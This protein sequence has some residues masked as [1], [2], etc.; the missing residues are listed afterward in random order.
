[1]QICR[2]Y[3]PEKGPRLGFVHEGEVYDLTGVAPERFGSLSSLLANPRLAD[4][5][6]ENQ[7]N[8]LGQEHFAFE[9]LDGP[10]APERPHLLAPI[11]R[12]EV[13]AAGVTYLRS[14]A[15]RVEESEAA[16]NHYERVY[17]APR[18]ELFFKGT[19]H[20]TVGPNSPVRIRTDSNWNVPEPELAL[21]ISPDLR[22]A[23]FT[24]GNDMSSRDIE[25]ENPLYLPQAKIYLE[26]CAL[27]PVVTLSEAVSNPQALSITMAVERGEEVIFSGQTSTSQ[28]K[29]GFQELINYL[30]RANAFPD[31]VFL[32]TG[33]GIVPPSDFTLEDGDLVIM[34]IEAIGTLRNPVKRA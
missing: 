8:I 19:P 29:R 4:E 16:A 17:D 20:R 13:W 21:L 11:D 27:G 33:T 15:A 7:P 6:D 12:Q 14:R 30:G 1:M 10:P 23:G 31:G 2:F 5:L 26:S 9:D 28:M 32:L 3:R 24:V 22:L 18:P 34:T 25:G